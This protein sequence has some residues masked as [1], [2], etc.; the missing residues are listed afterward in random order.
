MSTLTRLNKIAEILESDGSLKADHKLI[1]IKG[2]KPTALNMTREKLTELH[3][4]CCTYDDSANLW[5][6]PV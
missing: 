4:L 2:P 5:V 1:Y 6:V 3:G